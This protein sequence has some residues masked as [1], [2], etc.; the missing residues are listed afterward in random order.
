MSSIKI[1]N[2]V[3][4]FNRV[5]AVS[6]IQTPQIDGVDS[7]LILKPDP[8]L[9][10][11]QYLV[12]EPTGTGDIHIRAGGVMDNSAATLRLGGEYNNVQVSDSGRYIA[13]ITGMKDTSGNWHTN[14]DGG[15]SPWIFMTEE[16][17][18]GVQYKHSLYLPSSAHIGQEGGIAT[19]HGDITFTGNLNL[20]GSATF[21]NTEYTTTSSISVTNTGTGP[22]LV[23]NQT[24]EQAIAAFYDDNSVAFYID[25][26]TGTGGYV[27][28]GTETPS[29]KLTVVGNISST[30]TMYV[31]SVNDLEVTTW[32]SGTVKLSNKVDG[33]NIYIQSTNA[34]RSI[35]RWHSR[36][37]YG[38]GNSGDFSQIQAQSD[39]VWIKNE[40]WSGGNYH[41]KWHFDNAGSITFPILNG[42]QRTGN[43]E[44][45]QFAKTGQQ[46]LISTAEGTLSQPTV[47][48]LVIAGGD[49][50][51]DNE[52]TSSYIG[53]GGDIY[54]WAGRGDNGGDIK[55]DAGYGINSGGT[56]K[57]RSGDTLSGS[58][59]FVEIYAGSSNYGY[60]GPIDIHAG[61]GP[62][63]SGNITLQTCE[64]GTHSLILSSTGQLIVPSTLIVNGAISATGGVIGAST[65]QKFVSAFGNGADTLYEIYHN[66]GTEDVVVTI[67][68]TTTKEVV[69]PSVVNYTS[70]SIKVEFSTA[71]SLT[72]Y[73]A[74]VLG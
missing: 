74:V 42:N 61:C 33:D 16:I 67:L 8:S 23:V 18:D 21:H 53:E 1:L 13:N 38:S 56:T 48:R 39:G 47:E 29:E 6:G 69:Y 50:Y 27:G 62:L 64:N 66:L 25:G 54:L 31:S 40:S 14:Y 24:G 9:N 22:A 46:K 70:N 26:K 63:G 15:S 10:N 43:G 55:V 4:L 12:V 3:S 65:I 7:K 73:K 17:V 60:G 37:E 34:G 58:G 71:P 44:N 28:V 59:G 45:L 30:G 51:Y 36:A 49:S 68:D 20:A 32:G 35:L 57:I 11:D 52:I 72:A 19:W 41:H 5:T 2:N